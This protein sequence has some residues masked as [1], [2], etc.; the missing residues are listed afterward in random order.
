MLR[1]FYLLPVLSVLLFASCSPTL[2]PFTAD[3]YKDY[4]WTENE[5]KQIQFYV[6]EDIKLYR[7]TKQGVSEVSNGEIKV[8][9]GKRSEIIKIPAGTP[10]TLLFLPEK[11]RF[12]VSFEPESDKLFLMF[13]PGKNVDGRFVLLASEWD[14]RI[15]VI[16]YGDRKYRTRSN[17]AWATLMVDLK[18]I[19]KSEYEVRTAKGREIE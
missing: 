16:T 12:A 15:G 5:L 19:V 18:K 4:G 10:G 3:L 6:S 11:N 14:K 9:D 13:G 2:T 17:S 7:I 1:F 8:I